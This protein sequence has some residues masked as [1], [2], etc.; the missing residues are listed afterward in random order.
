MVT[1]TDAE[2]R[3]S[4]RREGLLVVEEEY[5]PQHVLARLE[6]VLAG[7]GCPLPGVSDDDR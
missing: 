5:R 7:D 4:L 6:E 3:R 2:L 1:L